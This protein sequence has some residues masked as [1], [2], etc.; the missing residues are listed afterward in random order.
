M[1][2]Q[3]YSSIVSTFHEYTYHIL[4]CGAIGSAAATQI[5]RMGGTELKLYDMDYVSDENLGVS[6]F[7]V[8]DLKK[9]KTEALELICKTINPLVDIQCFTKRFNNYIPSVEGNDIIILGFDS[10]QSRLEAVEI[11]CKIKKPFL[12][13]DGRMGAEHYQQYVL[14]QP[15]LSKYKST[16]Y[17]DDEGSEEPCNAKATSYCSNM[18]GSFICNSVKQIL[19]EEPYCKDFTFNFPTMSLDSTGLYT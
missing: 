4:G 1:L 18:S 17:S 12:L 10:M 14:E 19:K 7:R 13:I 3:R 15:T 16:W 2:S 9:P 6:M 8:E 11:I 5:V